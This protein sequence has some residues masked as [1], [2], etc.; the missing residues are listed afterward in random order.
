MEVLKDGLLQGQGRREPDEVGGWSV[1]GMLP[2]SGYSPQ[3]L[4]A[5]GPR[6]GV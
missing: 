3:G 1:S 6:Q 5:T 2:P 4:T